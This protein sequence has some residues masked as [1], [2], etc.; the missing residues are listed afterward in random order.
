MDPDEFL[1][2][3][4]PPAPDDIDDVMIEQ[5]HTFLEAPVGVAEEDSDNEG[6]LIPAPIRWGV[7][8]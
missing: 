3:A 5:P 4:L 1:S 7:A 2:F 6:E 8:S